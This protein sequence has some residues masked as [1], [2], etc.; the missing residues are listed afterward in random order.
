MAANIGRTI[1][2]YI[3]V[4]LDDSIGTLRQLVVNSVGGIGLDYPEVDLTAWN[5][6]VQGVLLGIPSFSTTIG[7]PFDTTTHGYLSGVNG[8]N[9]PLS[10][11]VRCGIR[12]TYTAGEPQFGITSSATDGVLV[13]NYTVKPESGTWEA[14]IVMAAGSAAPAWGVAAEA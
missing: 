10:F 2:K 3:T 12:Q 7:G 6:A 14:T 13:K 8:L 1:F 11:D 5:D 9:V 4:H